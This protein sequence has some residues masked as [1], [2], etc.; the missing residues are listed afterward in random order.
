MTIRLVP[1]TGSIVAVDVTFGTVRSHLWS[2][3][4]PGL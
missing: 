2:I 3:S 1:L 4:R